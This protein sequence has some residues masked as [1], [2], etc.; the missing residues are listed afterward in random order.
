MLHFLRETVVPGFLEHR[1][2]IPFG[3]AGLLDR[4]PVTFLGISQ[5][6]TA[7]QQVG[8]GVPLI[9]VDFTAIIH[10][11]A[12]GPAVLDHGDL[13]ALVLDDGIGMIF[14]FCPALVDES[15]HIRGYT[16]DLRFAQHP[17]G[18][19]NRMTAHV[20]HH[21]AAGKI[22]IPEPG[23]VWAGMLLRLFGQERLADRAFF[24]Q[25]FCAHVFRRKQ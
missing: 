18:I 7:A 16:L 21:A 8:A 9:A 3:R 19:F 4:V 24:D 20:H 1:E 17:A 11:A 2:S 23:H 6:R 22:H 15:V 5:E 12:L 14:A 13:I 10:A 25:H